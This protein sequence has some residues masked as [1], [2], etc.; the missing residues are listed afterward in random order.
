M[1]TI[2]DICELLIQET[3]K[4]QYLAETAD[5]PGLSELL[6]DIADN[7]TEIHNYLIEIDDK[8]EIDQ[9]LKKGGEDAEENGRNL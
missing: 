7:I 9:I 6:L 4:V 8:V 2:K 5:T 1:Q 3:L